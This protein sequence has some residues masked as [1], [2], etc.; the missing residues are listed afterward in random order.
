M[1]NRPPKFL[2]HLQI[3][4]FLLA[5]SLPLLCK[6]VRYDP[7]PTLD[8][9]RELKAKPPLP[10]NWSELV[11]WPN[12]FETWQRD[13]FGLRNTLIWWHSVLLRNVLGV[14]PTPDTILGK[15]GWLFH[16]IPKALDGYRCLTPF[17][18]GE[19][20]SLAK[21]LQEKHQWL[22]QRQIA[23]VNVWVPLKANIYPEL[24]PSWVNKLDRP[25]RLQQWF[26]YM[27]A[28]TQAPV[29][30]LTS[31]LRAAKSQGELYYLTDTHWNP[32]GGFVGAQAI[33]QNLHDQGAP[34]EPTPAESIEYFQEIRHGGDL[35]RLMAMQDAYRAPEWFAKIT[36]SCAKPASANGIVREKGV[37]VRAFECERHR[38]TKLVMVHDS[39]GMNALPFLAE[40]FGRTLSIEFGDFDRDAIEREKPDAV[41]EIHLER[42]MTPD[43]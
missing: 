1:Q 16:G 33:L 26:T 32:R 9:Y 2:R 14:S 12:A 39:F 20:A 38:P 42:Q 4:L 27:R 37:N 28:H 43:R 6:I 35:A 15:D 10:R 19:L 40:S 18:D 24:L 5:I 11:A 8:E 13:R 23:Y 21:V 25:C 7:S 29:L 22:A 30:D 3:G 17:S 36:R 41:V 31:T 34:V